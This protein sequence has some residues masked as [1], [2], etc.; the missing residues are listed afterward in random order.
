MFAHTS[1][2]SL[3]YAADT[4]VAFRRQTNAPAASADDEKP[5][6]T[7]VSGVP[8][9]AA[10]RAGHT[11]DTDAATRYVNE[12]PLDENCWPFIDTV[13]RREPDPDDGG[14]AHSSC[15]TLTRRADV[16]DDNP[17]SK[18]HRSVAPSRNAEPTTDTRVPPPTGPADGTNALTH[19]TP[20][21]RK[22]LALRISAPSLISCQ[23]RPPCRRRRLATRSERQQSCRR[24]RYCRPTA[25]AEP[26]EHPIASATCDA[27]P[28]LTVTTVAAAHRT[29]PRL[30]RPSTTHRHQLKRTPLDVYSRPLVLTSTPRRPAADRR[31]VA[32]TS[33]ELAHTRADA[34]SRPRRQSS[35]PA[36]PPPT[37]SRRPAP[38]AACRPPPRRR[39]GHTD[40]HRPPPHWY[41]NEHAAR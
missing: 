4:T 1:D 30:A 26:N 18:R 11:D 13:T 19:S 14:D 9:S 25:D 12:T 15:A 2:D 40:A 27:R 37:R 41:V 6:P 32:H 22:L 7:T 10:T 20:C 17:A 33:A 38:S 16:D 21:T 35:A 23:P 39:A 5:T 31:R 3:T 28:T 34:P 29:A 24:P 8:P 36:P